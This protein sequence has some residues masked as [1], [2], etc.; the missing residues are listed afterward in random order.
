MST[1]ASEDATEILHDLE[2]KRSS[3]AIILVLLF[4]HRKEVVSLDASGECGWLFCAKGVL[5]KL[6]QAFR[7]KCTSIFAMWLFS[8]DNLADVLMNQGDGN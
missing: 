8:S 5:R 4:Y 6:I 1:Q 2:D 3:P 7:D